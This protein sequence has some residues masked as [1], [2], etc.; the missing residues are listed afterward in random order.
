MYDRLVGSR[1]KIVYNDD[2]KIFAVEGELLEWNSELKTLL[3]HNDRKDR[4]VYINSSVIHRIELLGES[5]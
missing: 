3:I 5:E 1:V 4:D 2:D